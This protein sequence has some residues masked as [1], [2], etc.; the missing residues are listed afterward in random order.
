MSLIS[1][2]SGREPQTQQRKR[3]RLYRYH[4]GLKRSYNGEPVS[5]EWHAAKLCK[6]LNELGFKA[7]IQGCGLSG[8]TRHMVDEGYIE[9]ESMLSIAGHTYDQLFKMD[10]YAYPQHKEILDIIIRGCYCDILPILK[11]NNIKEAD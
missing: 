2:K 4:L 10:I 7:K 11:A 9:Q 6:V 8:F 1:I 3:R 5:H